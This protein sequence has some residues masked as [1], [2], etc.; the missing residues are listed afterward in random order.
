ME[1]EAI[2]TSQPSSARTLRYGLADASS[3]TGDEGFLALKSKIHILSSW[4]VLLPGQDRPFLP[5][6]WIL[7]KGR[8]GGKLGESQANRV[9]T[10]RPVRLLL[11]SPFLTAETQRTQRSAEILA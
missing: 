5:S 1:R 8:F 2:T 3:T 10:K 7:H 9:L 4:R 6:F 11:F